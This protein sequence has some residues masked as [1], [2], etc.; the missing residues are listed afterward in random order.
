MMV[1]EMNER[2]FNFGSKKSVSRLL[3]VQIVYALESNFCY[4]N[5]LEKAILEISSLQPAKCNKLFLHTLLNIL[6]KE[7]EKIEEIIEHKI[8]NDSSKSRLSLL[9]RIIISLA[10]A[11]IMHYSDT[12]LRIILTEFLLVGQF[13]VDKSSLCFINGLLDKIGHELRGDLL[14]QAE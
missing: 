6:H 3:A 5:N 2:R 11:E 10:L 14:L 4:A 9:G 12:D 7:G 8:F 1:V 13:F